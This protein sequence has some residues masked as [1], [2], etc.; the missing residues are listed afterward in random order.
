VSFNVQELSIPP[1]SIE[2]FLDT[3]AI[4]MLQPAA[5]I[6]IIHIKTVKRPADAEMLLKFGCSGRG[7]VGTA[8][9]RRSATDIKQRPGLGSAISFNTANVLFRGLELHVG[10]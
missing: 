10:I 4:A 1:P 9:A 5:R 7:F 3:S 2:D 8:G 6:V